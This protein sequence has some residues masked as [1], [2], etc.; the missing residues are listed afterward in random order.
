MK[1][2]VKTKI[3]NQPTITIALMGKRAY[4]FQRNKDAVYR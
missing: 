3:L 2:L 4:P 1:K